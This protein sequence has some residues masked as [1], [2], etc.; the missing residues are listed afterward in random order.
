MIL[1]RARNYL[2]MINYL[3][4]NFLT[5]ADKDNN[6][7]DSTE[8]QNYLKAQKQPSSMADMAYS[9]FDLNKDGVLSQAELEAGYG[10]F[11]ANNDGKLSFSENIAME[12]QLAGVQIDT[13]ISETRYNSLLSLAKNLF[14][15]INTSNTGT[16]SLTEVQNYLNAKNV[17]PGGANAYLNFYDVNN[18]GQVNVFEM[19]SKSISIDTNVNTDGTV[20][21]GKID[22]TE[23]TALTNQLTALTSI[24]I[25]ARNFVKSLDGATGT[26]DANG[27]IIRDGVVSAAE[28]QAYLTA[29][30]LSASAA[31][32]LMNLY[33]S[34]G[35]ISYNELVSAYNSFDA[36]GNGVLS[37]NESMGLQNALNGTTINHNITATQYNKLYSASAS[38]IKKADTNK[39]GLVTADEYAAILDASNYDK[40]D[41][42]EFVNFYDLNGDGISVHEFLQRSIDLDTNADGVLSYDSTAKDGTVTQGEMHAVTSILRKLTNIEIGARNLVKGLNKDA[43]GN[44]INA[45]GSIPLAN[46]AAYLTKNKMPLTLADNM[47]TEYGSGTS[48]SYDQLVAAYNSFDEDGNGTLSFSESI[49]FQNSIAG[50]QFDPAMSS[51]QYGKLLKMGQSFMAADVDK[52]GKVDV[53]ELRASIDA[54]NAKA[55]TAASS[56]PDGYAENLIMYFDQLQKDPNVTINGGIV[57]DAAVDIF[58]YMKGMMTFDVNSDGTIN[59]TEA[60]NY[61]EQMF[62]TKLFDNVN[63][64]YK[65]SD[66]SDDKKLTTT[67]LRSYFITQ[68]LPASLVDEMAEEFV[69]GK[70]DTDNDGQISR[71]EM[72]NLYKQFDVNTNNQLD[73]DERLNL[74][75]Y[76][77]SNRIDLGINAANS[78]QYAN[79]F[80]SLQ[81]YIMLNDRDNN[82]VLNTNELREYF[83]AQ[84]LP[85]YIVDAFIA[86]YDVATV[87]DGV[88]DNN[89]D[90]LEVMKAY[91]DFDG[92][93]TGDLD[94]AEVLQMNSLLSGVQLNATQD[95]KAQYTSIYN[96]SVSNLTK[97]D[98]N[99][100][101]LLDT[102]EV[103]NYLASKG[104]TAAYA[105]NLFK[106]Y[107][108]AGNAGAADGAIDLLELMSAEIAFD[109]DK[110]GKLESSEE[111]SLFKSL[112]SVNLGSLNPTKANEVEY[113]RLYD[114]VKGFLTQYDLSQD[115]TM[116]IAELTAFFRDRN[117]PASVAQSLINRFGQNGTVDA[118]QFLNA[119]V[120]YDVEANGYLQFAERLALDVDGTNVDVNSTESHARQYE[121]LYNY[122]SSI[123]SQYDR[124]NNDQQ[125]NAAEFVNYLKDR[126]FSADIANHAIELYDINKDGSI[127]SIELLKANIDYDTNQNGAIELNEMLAQNAT[128]AQINGVSADVARTN[129]V[130]GNFNYANGILAGYDTDRDGVLSQDETQLLFRNGYG[131][132][133]FAAT[134]FMN[135]NDVNKDGVLNNM[136]LM[137]GYIQADTDASGGLEF[138]NLVNFYGNM[139]GVQAN[140]TADNTNQM[141]SL[142]NQVWQVMAYD[143]DG[144]REL[145]QADIETWFVTR[146]LPA[147][148]GANFFRSSVNP[149]T[150][151]VDAVSLLRAFAA[152]DNAGNR[153]GSIYELDEQFNSFAANSNSVNAQVGAT[154]SNINQLGSLWGQAWG[155]MA[156]DKDGD[157]QL[158]R[159]DIEKWFVDRGL[160]ASVGTNFFSAHRNENGFVDAM[161]LLQAFAD[162][163][164]NGNRN[165]SIYELDEQLMSFAANSNSA[166]AQV[167]INAGNIN[168]LGSLWGQANGVVNNARY[169]VDGDRQLTR[170]D[171]ERWFVD[172]G[173][174]ASVGANFFAAHRNEY[175]FVDAMTML[176]A[177]TEIDNNVTNGNSN[178]SIYDFAEQ[179]YTYS[180]NSNSPAASVVMTA[181]ETNQVAGLWNQAAGVMGYD[182]DGDRQLSLANI[183][184]WFKDQ[185]L[186]AYMATNFFNAHSNQNGYVD[187]MTLTQALREIDN[188]G[189]QNGS[190]ADFNETIA[191]YS[192][193]TVAGLSVNADNQTQIARL[194]GMANG[195]MNY[196]ANGNNN[197]L[198]NQAELANYFKDL[199]QTAE[200][201]NNFLINNDVNGDGSL[202]V[203]EL[204]NALRTVDS[205]GQ[206]VNGVFEFDDYFRMYNNNSNVGIN[207]TAANRS[208]VEN[209]YNFASGVMGYDAN[210]DRRLDANE[211]RAYFKNTLAM[212]AYMADNFVN[213]ASLNGDGAVDVMELTKAFTNI[214]N[215]G[216]NPDGSF[217][218][219]DWMR[220]HG[221]TSRVPTTITDANVAQVESLWNN[222]AGG[223]M[224]Y[225]RSGNLTLSAAEIGEWFKTMNMSQEMANRFF[226]SYVGQSGEVDRMG[227]LRAFT[228]LDSNNSGAIEFGEQINLLES[229]SR[230]NITAGYVSPQMLAPLY[231][232]A[233]YVFNF[234]VVNQDKQIQVQEFEAYAQNYIGHHETWRAMAQNAFRNADVDGNGFINL[235]EM[236]QTFERFDLDRNGAIDGTEGGTLWG[237]LTGAW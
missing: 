106:N 158:T 3:A 160:P 90:V 174:P 21:D 68:G 53:S 163:D 183:Q 109:I 126:G 233:S 169:D 82:G 116:D 92:D 129:Q 150:G 77:D 215:A 229:S 79:L 41:A 47:L 134:Q 85:T 87:A 204:T 57:K 181:T 161:T 192:T 91:I 51:T 119:Y 149:N 236:V 231:N 220:F 186:P 118:L 208:Q 203:M 141:S 156:Y 74:Y 60:L 114:T 178:G 172:Q 42:G 56:V 86:Q 184:Q 6:G 83:R 20:G 33:G 61:K 113:Q 76:I 101:K 137:A 17:N 212:P 228:A 70:Y 197:R 210:A 206:N 193:T 50:I 148:V 198:L 128:F 78:R 39:D 230:F 217:D 11:D 237:A 67:E 14:S 73:I 136:E 8:Y 117:L 223:L 18:D 9:L 168:Q 167:V 54:I 185:G 227:L 65:I 196:D 4:Y 200:M 191:L 142:W 7:V 171:V 88:K 52:N 187:A 226:N 93:K 170:A 144:N 36:D 46:Y 131:I 103:N 24:E 45:D 133:G 69:N 66:A 107:D 209:L 10:L 120:K 213:Q 154:S 122:G 84:N 182:K 173:L 164:N 175:G 28:Y 29:K 55:T 180:T 166:N 123:I 27:N 222:Y 80:D 125:L 201:S 176:Q 143:R 225:D 62:N 75:S 202:D 104:L 165:G 71:L 37:F 105:T 194:W 235:A 96:E 135:L 108:K 95:N 157:H 81:Q 110:T 99:Q 2:G 58:E 72:M 232:D 5:S 48:I 30:G 111:M 152:I 1:E 35:S 159:A 146:G 112:S 140:I 153:N 115:K 121:P 23:I 26:K 13:T 15:S 59:S 63:E 44:L 216:T 32:T 207:I 162:I 190:T 22:P 147:S 195:I 139:V 205:A 31:Q 221:Q 40:A 155:V 94:V 145:T 25:G 132:S 234:E 219:R 177:F 218:Y 199:G 188:A 49:N 151:T 97:F 19:L 64:I 214:D 124:I 43:E 102:F 100:D 138:D 98:L 38:F 89:L 130:L 179:M 211:M 12:N 224:G 189:N 34:N 16:A 127:D